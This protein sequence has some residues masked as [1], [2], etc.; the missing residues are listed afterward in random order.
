MGKTAFNPLSQWRGRVGGQV[1]KV[2]NGKQVVVPYSGAKR[3][4]TSLAQQSVQVRFALAGKLSK[5][6]PAEILAGLNG[7]K[8]DRRSE[9][10][11][12]ITKRATVSVID[13]G[14]QASI[15]APNVIFSKGEV[16]NIDLSGITMNA[17]GLITGNIA[18]INE[19]VDAVLVIGVVSKGGDY[20]N[21]V[22]QVAPV[23]NSA[24][25]VNLS[26]ELGT[27]VEI[28]VQLYYVPLT[29][30]DT[31]RQFLSTSEYDQLGTG[32]DEYVLNMLLNSVE[33]AYKWG[34]SQYVNALTV[35]NP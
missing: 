23:E 1:Y 27:G 35:T 29:V 7:S 24:A 12:N 34:Q 17:A 18:N 6:T 11:R 22:Y 15:D 8:V 9:F 10:T 25:T 14:F 3:K 32:N 31:A 2:V 13:D 16:I 28:T 5:I 19:K 30:S 4:S 21:V 26:N 33:G 20:T